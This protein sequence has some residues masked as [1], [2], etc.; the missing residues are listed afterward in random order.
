MPASSTYTSAR[1]ATLRVVLE[2][3]LP[4]SVEGVWELWTTPRGLER[5]FGSEEFRTSVRGLDVRP[6]GKIEI[7]LAYRPAA[8]HPSVAREFASSGLDSTVRVRGSFTDIVP[9]AS[10]AFSLTFD[11]GPSAQ[12][13]EVKTRVQ[14]RPAPGTVRMYLAMESAA[15]SHWRALAEGNLQGLADRLSSALAAPPGM[16]ARGAG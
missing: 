14:F 8:T 13:H 11:F 10:L 12:L 1:P 2:R 5:W 3:T 4:G 16:G 6:G 9:R 7:D 15:T